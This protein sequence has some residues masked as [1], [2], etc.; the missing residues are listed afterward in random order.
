VPRLV[1]TP[2]NPDGSVAINKATVINEQFQLSKQ[3]W[4]YLSKQGVIENP[5]DFIRKVPHMSFVRGADN[6]EFLKKRH[7]AMSSH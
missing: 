4:A 3:F 2:V 7:E 1:Y 6:I 5:Q